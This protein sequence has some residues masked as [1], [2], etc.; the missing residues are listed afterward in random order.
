MAPE[1]QIFFAVAKRVGELRPERA[2][3]ARIHADIAGG[4]GC[5]EAAI[6]EMLHVVGFREHLGDERLQL[7]W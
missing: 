7:W 1:G 5:V 2:E 3:F 6:L 4:G